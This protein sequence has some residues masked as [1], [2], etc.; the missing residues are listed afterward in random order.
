[1]N[2]LVGAIWDR[3]DHPLHARLGMAFHLVQ[4]R[5]IDEDPVHQE[6]VQLQLDPLVVGVH[7]PRD[8][9]RHALSGHPLLPLFRYHDQIADI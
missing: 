2:D 3:E 7:A 6:N 5:T 4:H 9:L 8:V 1:M